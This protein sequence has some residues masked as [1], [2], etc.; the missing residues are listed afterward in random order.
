ME[1]GV[2]MTDATR[3]ALIANDMDLNAQGLA[4]W[5]TRHG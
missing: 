2:D 3:A 4:F 1:H 5:V